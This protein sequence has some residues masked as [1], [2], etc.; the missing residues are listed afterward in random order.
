MRLKGDFLMKKTSALKNKTIIVGCSSLGAT[1]TNKF[2]IEGKNLMVIDKNPKN[3]DRLSDRFSGYTITGDVSDLEVLEEAGIGS[4]KDIVIVTNDDNLNL[5]VAHIARKI[6]DV[7]NIYI[8]LTEP[9]NEILLKGMDIKA[10][11]PLELSYDKFNVL[12]G[13][14]K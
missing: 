2:S 14:R 11:Y 1:I 6:Y 12:R 7:P 13:G 3:F 9:D 8:R 4:A 5:F 10:I